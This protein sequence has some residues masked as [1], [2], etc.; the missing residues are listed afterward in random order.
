MFKSQEPNCRYD[1]D[2]LV[3]HAA[4]VPVE[5]SE[6]SVGAV[7]CIDLPQYSSSSAEDFLIACVLER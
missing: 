6:I 7:V 1:S 3:C 5:S 2:Y 4:E